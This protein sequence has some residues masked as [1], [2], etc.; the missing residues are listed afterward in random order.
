MRATGRAEVPPGANR[1]PSCNVFQPS[2]TV[3]LKHGNRRQQPTGQAIARRREIRDE[4][5]RSLGGG[6]FPPE[7]SAALDDFAFVRVQLD[8]VATY[9]E[10]VGTFTERGRR[11]AA[12]DTYLALSQR[13]ERIGAQI[14]DLNA[15]RPK[16][17][18]GDNADLLRRLSDEELQALGEVVAAYL[19]I[20]RVRMAS[21]EP[22]V[23][24]RE[25]TVEPTGGEP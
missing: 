3:A 11:R 17:Q 12:L 8:T 6:Y 23:R 16:T 15:K 4:W 9:L 22:D 2:N 18:S 21:S 13:A 20:G 14:Q 19:D 24:T 7:L 1:C 10:T 5:A 25:T